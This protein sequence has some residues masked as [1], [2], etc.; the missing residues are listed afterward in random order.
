[1]TLERYEQLLHEHSVLLYDH[2]A[3]L[4]GNLR[5][6]RQ[7]AAAAAENRRLRT[8]YADLAAQLT[9]ARDRLRHCLH[10]R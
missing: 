5:L 10:A 9:A 7:L 8:D 4:L 3:V 6:E 2:S 1:M